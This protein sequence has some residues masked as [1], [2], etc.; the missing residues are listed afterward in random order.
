MF[1]DDVSLLAIVDDLR[2]FYRKKYTRGYRGHIHMDTWIQAID[3][4]ITAAG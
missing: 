1:L 2:A 3:A 4:V